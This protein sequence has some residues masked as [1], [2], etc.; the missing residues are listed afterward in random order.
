MLAVD[1]PVG[2]GFSYVNTNGYVHE[3]DEVRIPPCF[4]FLIPEFIGLASMENFGSL[5]S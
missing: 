2:T 1:Q 5:S 3:L 4:A